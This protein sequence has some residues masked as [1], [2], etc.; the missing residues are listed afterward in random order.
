LDPATDLAG[1]DW[2][3][4]DFRNCDLRGFDFRNARL[5]WANLRN[6]LVTGADFRGAGDLHTTSIQYARGWRAALMDE[7]QLVRIEGLLDRGDRQKLSEMDVS[8]WIRLLRKARDYDEA[9]GLLSEMQEGLFSL[10]PF[11][12]AIAIGKA[13]RDK[14]KAHAQKLFSEYLGKGGIT[15]VPLYTALMDTAGSPYEASEIFNALLARKHRPDHY[16]YNLYISKQNDFRQAM[17]IFKNMLLHKHKVT[18]Y[19]AFSLFDSCSTFAHAVTV[20]LEIHR[21][22]IDIFQS[23]ILAEMVDRTRDPDVTRQSVVAMRRSGADNREILRRLISIRLNNPW[24]KGVLTELGLLA[25]SATPPPSAAP[26]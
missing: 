15:D 22:N 19:T 18:E 11:A 7:S 16:F 21:Q 17:A 14:E 12:Y 4:V 1:G 6:A 25:P 24:R 8:G 2:R 26:Q 13:R 9:T 10:N 3:K 20:L 5:F 23:Q